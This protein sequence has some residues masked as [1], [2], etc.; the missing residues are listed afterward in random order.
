[1]RGFASRATER[2]VKYRRGNVSKGK[3]MSHG[4]QLKTTGFVLTGSVEHERRRAVRRVLKT[5]ND[6]LALLEEGW[7]TEGYLR[8]LDKALKELAEAFGEE[9]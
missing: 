3:T 9:P 8:P 2:A 1:M 4:N 7:P 6:L 5:G